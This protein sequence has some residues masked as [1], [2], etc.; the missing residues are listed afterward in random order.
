LVVGTPARLYDLF[1]ALSTSHHKPSTPTLATIGNRSEDERFL[2]SGLATVVVEGFFDG[3]GPAV[4]R[5]QVQLSR[6]MALLPRPGLGRLTVVGVSSTAVA[7]PV[8]STVEKW[9]RSVDYLI[10]SKWVLLRA[11]TDIKN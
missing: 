9:N 2:L 8:Q 4:R 3:A 6:L 5:K 10:Q 11:V 7:E 1:T